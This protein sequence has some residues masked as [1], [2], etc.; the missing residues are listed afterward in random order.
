M[1]WFQRRFCCSWILMLDLPKSWGF[2]NVMWLSHALARADSGGLSWGIPSLMKRQKQ[3]H[4]MTQFSWIRQI[5]NMHLSFWSCFSGMQKPKI[6]FSFRI[7]RCLC[8]KLNFVKLRLQQ[9]WTIFSSHHIAF[10]ILDLLS[11]F[12]K[13]QGDPSR[14]LLVVVGAPSN[15]FSDIKNQVKCW[16]EWARFHKMF[17]V[18]PNFHFS[19]SLPHWKR[20]LMGARPNDYCVGM[21]KTGDLLWSQPF[22]L[23]AI[24]VRIA[25]GF[26]IALWWCAPST[27]SVRVVV[28]SPFHDLTEA[29]VLQQQKSGNRLGSCEL[30]KMCQWEAC[31][32]CTKRLKWCPMWSF[33]SQVLLFQLPSRS[34]PYTFK[35]KDWRF[36]VITTIWLAGNRCANSTWFQDSALM[37]RSIHILSACGCFFTLSRFDG[38][39]CFAAAKVREQ[40][41]QLWACQDVSIHIYNIYNI[42]IHICIL[43]DLIWQTLCSKLSASSSQVMLFLFGQ[44]EMCAIIIFRPVRWVCI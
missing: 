11:I 44:H 42:Y 28:F 40:V 39:K 13:R 5:V 18:N 25:R 8:M 27:F 9:A 26:K 10:D 7:C 15:Q 4:R 1:L 22:G 21:G 32:F 41:G 20:S 17:G 23:L 37:M 19:W 12:C 24:V 16:L 31:V 30:V 29:N 2:E 6:V 35:G 34:P 14:S 33:S 36:V 38:S 3:E 43:N